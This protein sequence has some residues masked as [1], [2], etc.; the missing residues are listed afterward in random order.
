ME[1][2]FTDWTDVALV[3]WLERR[4]RQHDI[5]SEQLVGY[6]TKAVRDLLERSDLDLSKL[7]RAKFMLEKVLTDKIS[8]AR[9]EA[10]KKAFQGILD[11]GLVVTD[12]SF[13]MTFDPNH[14]P[15]ARFYEGHYKFR[16]HYY[17]MIG[18]LNG[19]EAECAMALDRCQAVEWWVR[20]LER[21]PKYSFSLQTSSD[22]FY[23]DFVAKLKDG[24]MLVLEYKGSQFVDT[25]D[26][27]E[28]TAIG[29]IWAKNSG[30]LFLMGWYEN[31]GDIYQQ[32]ERVLEG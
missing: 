10:A 13:N 19:E 24:R 26:V 27:K 22:R 15:A 14:Y 17:P 28:K 18:D 9:K 5:L 30:N 4:L 20:N 29:N 11:L 21:Q 12:K 1:G 8:D 3:Q 32:L 7:V 16:K 25:P 2:V 6:L 23:P 31:G